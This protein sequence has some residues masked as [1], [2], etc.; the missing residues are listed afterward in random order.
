MAKLH[1]P[2]DGVGQHAHP[3]V[4]WAG[5]VDCQDIGAVAQAL[6][7]P[8]ASA[9]PIEGLDRPGIQGSSLLGP[10]S[11]PVGQGVETLQPGGHA[12]SGRKLGQPRG[13]ALLG[14]RDERLFQEMEGRLKRARGSKPC[15]VCRQTY[16]MSCIW[17][18][19]D[20]ASVAMS[21]P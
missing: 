13:P 2:V 21:T 9:V 18:T 8:D 11:H 3:L 4:V 5:E 14:Q 12:E 15:A 6:E 16:S 10:Q 17:T 7:D 20:S 1:R 19:N